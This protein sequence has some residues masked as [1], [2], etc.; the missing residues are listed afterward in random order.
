MISLIICS[1]SHDVSPQF[2]DNIAATIGVD[3][4]I[5]VVDNH[6]NS[7]NI[8][9]AYNL[10]VSEAHGDILCF[11]HED[12]IMQTKNWGATVEQHFR[13]KP[14]M[15]MLGVVG[16]HVVPSQG[17]W[18]VGYARHHVLSFIQRIP[19]FGKQAKYMT[20]HTVDGISSNMTEVATLDGVWFCIPQRLF[21]EHKLYFDDQTFDSFHVYD[22]DISMQVLQAGMKLYLCDDILLEHFSEGNY[23][24]GFLTSLQKFQKKW[25]D[26]LP[27]IVGSSVSV[28]SLKQEGVKAIEALND[29]IERD[30]NVV[31]IR[32]YWDNNVMGIEGGTLTEAQ[33]SIIAFSEFFYMKTA[34]KFHPSGSIVRKMLCEYMK[35]ELVEHKT[36]ILWKF[37]L[38]RVLHLNYKKNNIKFPE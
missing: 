22:L 9:T 25:K 16:S 19:T 15:G 14:E 23:S 34:I 37:F 32:R 20:K 13:E 18:R 8:F 6:D 26:K 10:G 1:K 12:L 28:E 5:V 7:H 38:Y 17:D 30:A 36:L 24:T 27:V 29:R 35:D 4:E 2:R 31:A 3:Y 21:N 11:L 33:K